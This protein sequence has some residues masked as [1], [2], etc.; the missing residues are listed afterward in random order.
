MLLADC[1]ATDDGNDAPTVTIT[2]PDDGAAYT[3]ADEIG[4]EGSADDTDDGDLSGDL[5]WT[6]D[7]DGQ[8]GTGAS[9]IATLSAGDHT[10]TAEA[11][12]SDGATGSDTVAVSITDA[13]GF[14][15]D[16]EG[17]PA[18]DGWAWD[19]LWHHADDTACTDPDDGYASPTNSFYYGQEDTCD[20]DTGSANSGSLTS[21][22]IAGG[23][24]AGE[25]VTL[26]FDYWREVESYDGAYDRAEAQVSWDGGDTW[27]TVWAKDARDTSQTDW[28]SVSLDLTAEADSITVRFVFDTVDGVANGYTGWLVDDLTVTAG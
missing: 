16:F 26:A 12:D 4:F 15:A 27:D 20:Y 9:F 24:T 14:V 21:P 22:A 6:S 11:T 13:D 1:D 19:G 8:I 17:D 2:S 25:P 5:T 10:V 23:V 18:A 7:L 3:T 28:L